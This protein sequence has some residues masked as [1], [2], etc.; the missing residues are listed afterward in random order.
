MRATDFFYQHNV[1][2]RDEFVDARR[3]AGKTGERTADSLLRNHVAG[4]DIKRIRRG[5]YASV[6]SGTAQ[7]DPYVLATKLAPDAVVAYHAA[8]EF[9]GK[10]YSVWFRYLVV[11]ATGMKPFRFEGREFV[12]VKPPKSLRRFKDLGGHIREEPHAGGVVRVTSL[13]RTLVDVLDRPDLGGGWEE[14]WRS[15]ES[16]EFFDISAVTSYALK[17]G[18][19]ITIARTG[20]FLEQHSE[21]LSVTD[22][23]LR[24][25]RAHAP[26]QPR[27]FDER[28][29]RG[30]LVKGWNLIVPTRILQRSWEERADA[31]T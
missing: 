31:D 16:V 23:H 6:R 21:A 17:L 18:S 1:F 20:F 5:V 3:R 26:S 2:T 15:L 9:F 30:S 13:E 27:Y 29:E 12:P 14:I 7:L 11:T 4:G 24:A 19:A 28:R 22:E 10:A 8:L 25:L